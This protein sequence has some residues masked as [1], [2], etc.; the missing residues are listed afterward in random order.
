MSILK[1]GG[2]EKVF[3]VGVVAVGRGEGVGVGILVFERRDKK[4][5]RPKTAVRLAITSHLVM[6]ES[7]AESQGYVKVG[8][9]AATP[10]P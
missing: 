7:V 10:A 3:R 2:E 8:A 1:G 5:I 9:R 6:G 4:M